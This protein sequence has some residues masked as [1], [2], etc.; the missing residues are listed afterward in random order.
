MA[1]LKNVAYANKDLVTAYGTFHF[2]E[3][4]ETEIDESAGKK[5]ATIQGFSLIGDTEEPEQKND[6]VEQDA[7]EDEQGENPTPEEEDAQETEENDE[8]EPE[9]E[10]PDESEDSEDE[11]PDD[12]ENPDENTDEDAEEDEIT[13]DKLQ[14]YTVAELKKYAKDNGIDIGTAYKKQDIIN[15]IIGK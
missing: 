10:E 9:S 3:T 8:D 12:S 13:E 6:S 14:E 4:G 1:T 7:E 15:V 2:S 5:L 11:E